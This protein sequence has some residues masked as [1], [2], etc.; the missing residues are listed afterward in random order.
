M[1]FVALSLLGTAV[2]YVKEGRLPESLVILAA[3]AA[4]VFTLTLAANLLRAPVALDTQKQQEILRVR[5]QIGR[6]ESASE[7]YERLQESCEA[8]RKLRQA[9]LASGDEHPLSHWQTQYNRWRTQ[10]LDT[11]RTVLSPGK[12]AFVDEVGS[13]P[14]VD[15]IG[16]GPSQYRDAKIRIIRSIEARLAKVAALMKEQ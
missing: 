14:A 8:G 6:L 16:M 13:L 9:V 10:L 15:V 12:A 3:A 2:A 7:A 5:N 11:V 1:S 4:L